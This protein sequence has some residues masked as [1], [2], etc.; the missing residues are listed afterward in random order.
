MLFHGSALV[1]NKGAIRAAPQVRPWIESGP[2]ALDDARGRRGLPA[3]CALREQPELKQ[4]L[5]R[6]LHKRSAVTAMA[7]ADILNSLL[8]QAPTDLR[9]SVLDKYG[10][11]ASIALPEV[12]HATL[13]LDATQPRHFRFPGRFSRLLMLTLSGFLC[14]LSHVASVS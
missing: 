3:F 11:G 2:G 13:I 1:G 12:F 7:A 4:L 9:I 8:R 5:R 10:K 6:H 14:V